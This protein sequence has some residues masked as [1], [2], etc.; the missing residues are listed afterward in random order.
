MDPQATA[1]RIVHYTDATER[2]TAAIV[3][4]DAA[5]DGLAALLTFF[6]G[7]PPTPMRQVPYAERPTP[8]C[9]S[10]MPY[11][12]A[13]AERPGGNQSESAEPRPT[14][15]TL[16]DF[17]AHLNDLNERLEVL[18]ERMRTDE[19]KVAEP[20]PDIEPAEGSR[21][22]GCDEEAVDRAAEPPNA[23]AER[24]QVGAGPAPV[25]GAEPYKNTETQVVTEPGPAAPAAADGQEIPSKDGGPDEA[26]EASPDDAAR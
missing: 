11:Q 19:A 10:W 24:E 16:E 13:K 5:P 26:Q 22:G 8:G 12:K 20:G 23:D 2:A 14:R 7:K 1:G 6:P 4:V 15:T 3:C 9:W 25:P 18:E 21:G 17:A